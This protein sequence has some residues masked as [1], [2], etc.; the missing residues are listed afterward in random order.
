MVF[1]FN[2]LLKYILYLFDLILKIFLN[3]RAVFERTYVL[4][5]DKS[6]FAHGLLSA[7][8]SARVIVLYTVSGYVPR[9]VCHA[10]E[11][12]F[13]YTNVDLLNWLYLD[14]FDQTKTE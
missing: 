5:I 4:S 1:L 10:S 12:R 3:Q 14:P 13:L 11:H 7:R 9:V 8:R 2:I 6:A